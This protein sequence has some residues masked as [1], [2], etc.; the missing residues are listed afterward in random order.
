M[1]SKFIIFLAALR[2]Y[3][4]TQNIYVTIVTDDSEALPLAQALESNTNVAKSYSN[5]MREGLPQKV[6]DEDAQI[7]NFRLNIK[8]V[9]I[10]DTK[11][12]FK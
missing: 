10:V 9:K 6:R 8:S 1:K 4:Q 11:D 2:K 5:L 12:T 7:A 3:F